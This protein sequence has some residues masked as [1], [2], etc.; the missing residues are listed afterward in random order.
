MTLALATSLDRWWQR[1][2]EAHASRR[3]PQRIPARGV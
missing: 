1:P 2:R 3:R